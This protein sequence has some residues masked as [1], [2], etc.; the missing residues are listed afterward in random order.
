MVCNEHKY[1][2]PLSHPVEKHK[3]MSPRA[4]FDKIIDKKGKLL[5]VLNYNLMIPVEDKQLVKIN[6]KEDKRDSVAYRPARVT[7]QP[8]RTAPRCGP[9]TAERTR[10]KKADA[11]DRE[12][13][14]RQGGTQYSSSSIKRLPRLSTSA[15]S[16]PRRSYIPSTMS[17][18]S[19]TLI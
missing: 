1:L 12:H 17:L 15:C 6:L 16:Y 18:S 2:I 13:H 8:S 19:G 10:I 5:G 14:S 3:K 11:D 4:D 7:R 9:A